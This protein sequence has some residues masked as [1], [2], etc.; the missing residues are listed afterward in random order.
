MTGNL[1]NT[2]KIPVR[3]QYNAQQQN[4]QN[5]VMPVHYE[6]TFTS[7]QYPTPQPISAAHI[8]PRGITADKPKGRLIKENIFQSAASTVKSYGNYAKY[9]YNAGFKGEG[10]DYSVGKIN[11]LAT[12]VGSLGIAATLAATKFF[13]FARGMEFVGLGTWFATMALWPKVLAIPVKA[14]TGVDPTLKYEDSMGR[15]KSFYEDRQYLC[16]DLFKHIDKNGNYNESAPEYELLHNIGDKLGIPR[17]IP[18]RLEAIQN[19]AGQVATQTN[20]LLM[21]TAGVMTPVLSS[22]IADQLQTPF[23]NFIEKARINKH[24]NNI[25]NLSSKI[26][27]VL[28]SNTSNLDEVIEKLGIKIDPKVN[29]KLNKYINSNESRFITPEETVEFRQLV[30]NRFFG[31]GYGSAIRD[32]L[33]TTSVITQDSIEINDKLGKDIQKITENVM[34]KYQ[35]TKLKNLE[36]ALDIVENTYSKNNSNPG[37]DTKISNILANISPKSTKQK[38]AKQVISRYGDITLQELKEALQSRNFDKLNMPVLKKQTQMDLTRI[39]AALDDT[40]MKAANPNNLLIPQYQTIGSAHLQVKFLD[41]LHQ[42]GIPEKEISQLNEIFSKEISKYFETNKKTLLNPQKAARLFKIGEINLQLKQQIDKYKSATI[43]NIAESMTARNWD[44]VPK[45]F[46][47]LIGFSKEEL[48][49]IS[50]LDNVKASKIITEK[51]S[52]LVKNEEKLNTVIT[53]MAELSNEAIT[54]EQKAFI[55]LVGTIEEPGIWRK[56]EILTNRLID[57]SGFTSDL[58]LNFERYYVT[59]IK[60]IRQKVANTID[61]FCR[62]IQAL[63]VFKKLDITVQRQLDGEN[64]IG[65]RI[66][67]PKGMP[68]IV[69]DFLGENTKEFIEKMQND[70][71]HA[72]KYYTFHESYDEPG[73]FKKAVNSLVAYIK[74]TVLDRNDISSWITKH[75]VPLNGY[76]KGIKHSKHMVGMLADTV[77][78]PFSESTKNAIEAGAKGLAETF[79]N[80]KAEMK[81]RY[82]GADNVLVTHSNFNGAEANHCAGINYESIVHDFFNTG[83][84]YEAEQKSK[85]LLQLIEDRRLENSTLEAIKNAKNAVDGYINHLR[86]GG[87]Y[88][89]NPDYIIGILNGKSANKDIGE[90]AGKNTVDFIV[91][92]AQN[93][94]SRNKWQ[95]VVW[96]LF[97]ATIGISAITIANMGH[98]NKFN[99]DLWKGNQQNGGKK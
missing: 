8:R 32:E 45:K 57:E 26:D 21:L 84:V 70:K 62:P 89:K 30:E 9:F 20:T 66:D 28:N 95:M 34:K 7:F 83:D 73:T 39:W 11:D 87:N 46:F 78:A 93:L 2:I 54:K 69:K 91:R 80:K 61:S 71:G 13:P 47:E 77:F 81:K 97:A 52:E 16:F 67:A 75:E 56:T 29:E 3:P 6:N 49:Q 88:Q 74:D 79:E 1:I 4:V 18:N 48:K 60:S 43:K 12:R 35:D 27:S 90:L 86:Y 82:L 23:G 50:A 99:P 44:K 42:T 53:K 58:K 15:R 31:T 25:H 38:A 51:F 63:D 14:K 59:T 64:V 55:E 72:N 33:S 98:T 94:R 96:S 76:T 85:K 19:K 10:T 92:A 22:I 68:A 37:P 36:T 65:H 40:K 17:N 41:Q 24:E 5:S